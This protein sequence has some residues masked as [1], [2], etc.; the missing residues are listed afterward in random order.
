MEKAGSDTVA[1]A[2]ATLIRILG[3]VPTLALPGV[4]ASAPVSV[5]KVAHAGILTIEKLKLSPLGALTTGVK[6][7][8]WPAVMLAGGVPLIVGAADG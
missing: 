5:L 4:P 6:P 2:A 3:N 7:K 8:D 1:S